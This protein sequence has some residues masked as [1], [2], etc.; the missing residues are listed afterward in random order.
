MILQRILPRFLKTSD[1]R[2]ALEMLGLWKEPA[3]TSLV[4]SLPLRYAAMSMPNDVHPYRLSVLLHP[5]SSR[6][7]REAV[8]ECI[9]AWM[10]DHT[11]ELRSLTR[12][13]RQRFAYPVAHQLQAIHLRVRF[14]ASPSAVQ[15]LAD[16]LRLQQKV[17]RV[18]L[19]KGET[20][21]GKRLAEVPVR[22]PE[23]T[24]RKTELK[25]TKE[26]APLEKLEEKIEEILE[27]EVL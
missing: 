4:F 8:E 14:A 21:D 19:W 25:A 27:E 16:L 2:D 9:S 22:R 7:E 24:S 1:R 18:R 5:Q 13:E 17:L 10:R 3:T 26:K 15:A 11:G 23:E 20:P 6:P 12:D